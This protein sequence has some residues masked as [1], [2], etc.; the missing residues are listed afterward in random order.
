MPNNSEREDIRPQMDEAA[1]RADQDLRGMVDMEALEKSHIVEWWEKWY[2]RTP[3]GKPG[4]G[5]KRLGRILVK[6]I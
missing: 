1:I 3:D 2:R 5:H 4:A 6:G